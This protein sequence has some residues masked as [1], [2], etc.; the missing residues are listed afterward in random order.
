MSEDQVPGGDEQVADGDKAQSEKVSSGARDQ[1]SY[2]T[3]KKTVTEAKRLKAQLRER[4]EALQ[5]LEAQK[6]EAEGNKEELISS[7]KKRLEAT[8]KMNK[9]ML[10]NFVYSSLDSQVREEAIKLGCVDPDAVTKL[11]DLSQVE[12]DPKT[13]KADRET[14]SSV[15]ED[16]RKAKPYLFGKSGPKINAQSPSGKIPEK[17]KKEF[18][19]MTQQELWDELKKLKSK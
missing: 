18:K 9:E 17:E 5:K 16:L 14:V 8:E 6:L 13:F 11:A 3:Y 2:D 15:L 10:N 1:V 4:E 7:L 12:V 19:Q